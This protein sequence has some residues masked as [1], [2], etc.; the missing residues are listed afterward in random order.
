MAEFV[1]AL[2]DRR[3]R[4]PG[5]VWELCRFEAPAEWAAAAP[6]RQR[7]QMFQARFRGYLFGIGTPASPPGEPSEELTHDV[8]PASVLRAS[9]L[10]AAVTESEDLPADPD[11]RIQVR[12]FGTRM[13]S[14]RW[15]TCRSSTGFLS[16]RPHYPA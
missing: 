6:F 4:Q 16:P 2:C 8:I 14:L 9:A 5:Q 10:L 1:T 13:E 3:V 7:A 12:P 11:Y 15:L